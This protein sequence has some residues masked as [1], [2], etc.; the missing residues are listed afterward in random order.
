MA[1]SLAP[2]LDALP[3]V[4]VVAVCSP[5]HGHAVGLARKLKVARAVSDVGSVPADADLYLISVKDAAV[6]EVAASLPELQSEAVVAH[7]SGSVDARALS[8]STGHF[9]V[10]Y[11]LQTF[12]K[13]VAVNIR[14]VPMFIEGAT[15]HA[16][17]LLKRV[18]RMISDNVYDADS[19]LRSK[20]HTAAVFACNFVNHLWAMADD[21]LHRE[22]GLDLSVLHPLIR[23]T[24]RKAQLVPPASVQTGPAVR[25]DESVMSKH[26]QM[27]KPDE[28]EIYELLSR[29]IMD[30]YNQYERH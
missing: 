25:G 18:A 4:D 8:V 19:T 6:A 9:G 29:H 20:M 27:L 17:D 7:T 14:E 28:A 12:S 10:F 24:M 2:A 26:L 21:I 23:E 30:F 1:S 5:T 16:S 22:A 11:P 15:L 3:D 13:D